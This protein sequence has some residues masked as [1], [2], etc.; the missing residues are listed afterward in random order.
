M[1]WTSQPAQTICQTS[2]QAALTRQQQLTK[3]PGS[4]GQ[5]EAI[6]VTLAGLQQR[7]AP[8]INHITISIFAADHGIAAENVSAFP[9]AVTAEMVRNF[10]GGGAAIAV[11]A[12][13]LNAQLRVCNV[14]TVTELE[15]INGV[16]STRIAAGTANFLKHEAMT[17]AQ[18]NQAL[19]IGKQH[20]ED[21]KDKHC[22]LW[23]GGEMGIANT[24]A[25]T[26]MA[27]ALLQQPASQLTG[28]GTGIDTAGQQ[29]KQSIIEQ[30]LK[31]HQLDLSQFDASAT[32]QPLAVLQKV[33]GFEIAALVG[34]YLRG[35]QLGVPMMV[36][37]FIASVA[38]L[39]ALRINPSIN[40][41]LFLGHKSAEPGHTA[42]VTAL[43][44]APLLQLEMRLGEASGA[45]MAVPLLKM[46]CALHNEMATFDSAQVSTAN[47]AS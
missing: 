30:A 35:A 10:A 2:Q 31:H 33:G 32:P 9:Q 8:Q 45:A 26:A 40:P 12:K 46:A 37:G 15:N 18:L 22:D 5:L 42:I 38:A 23:I 7:Q 43:N 36:D 13:Q 24:T 44:K 28:P 47:Q 29:H 17:T 16:E 11:L 39:T 25:A 34:A 3:P 21:A 27:C 1:S 19:A 41:W 4:L 6:A 14:G 20:L